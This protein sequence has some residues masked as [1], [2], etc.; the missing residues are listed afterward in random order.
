MPSTSSSTTA[1]SR[2]SWSL[3]SDPRSGTRGLIWIPEASTTARGDF[4]AVLTR[5]AA[6]PGSDRLRGSC[7]TGGRTTED[8]AIRRDRHEARGIRHGRA[9]VLH[10]GHRGH[11]LHEAQST[12]GDGAFLRRPAPDITGYS[13][14]Q[15]NH[16]P[17]LA[18]T[19]ASWRVLDRQTV[20]LGVAT[21]LL[22]LLFQ[23]TRLSK[24]ALILALAA[25]TGLA[26]AGT[27]LIQGAGAGKATPTPTGP[28]PTPR[29]TSWGRAPPISQ[30]ALSERSPAAARCPA[31]PS[32]SGPAPGR[33][34]PTSSPEA[35]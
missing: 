18:D 6:A 17:R 12:C 19:A 1:S 8:C 35:S 15:P 24:V 31:R 2:T 28:S 5:P 7:R 16:L 29:R 3:S 10:R 30:R 33:A 14:S 23:G 21:V 22:I 9:G 27:G 34:G 26:F 11:G 25:A 32:T 4:R 20:A 13:S